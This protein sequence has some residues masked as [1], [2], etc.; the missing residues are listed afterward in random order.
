MDIQPLDELIIGDASTNRN[1]LIKYLKKS[2]DVSLYN[3]Y[4]NSDF[5]YLSNI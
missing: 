3:Y 5:G 2:F 4:L 1:N